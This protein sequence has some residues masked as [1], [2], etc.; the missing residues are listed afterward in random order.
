MVPPSNSNA[1][2]VKT[3]PKMTVIAVV[4]DLRGRARRLLD[5]LAAQTVTDLLEVLVADVGRKGLPELEPPPGLRVEIIR[6][7]PTSTWGQARA[8]ALRQAR[9]PLVALIEDHCYPT[10]AWAEALLD[11]HRGPW[12]A[13]GYAFTNPDPS[14]YVSRAALVVDYGRWMH[15]ARGGRAKLLSFNNV[16]YKRDALESLEKPL[17]ALLATDFHVQQELRR[18]GMPMYVEARAVAAHE[19][20]SNL[21]HLLAANHD[22]SRALASDRSRIENWGR[23]RRLFHGVA[24]MAVAPLI[25]ILRLV[26]SLPGRR[27]VWCAVL[28]ASPV[29]LLSAVWTAVGES[30]GYLVGGGAKIEERIKHWEVYAKR[31]LGG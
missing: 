8:A 9:A 3:V 25:S 29:L 18:R 11:A 27:G 17:E 2:A 5:A 20:Y 24:T 15:P 28:A 22:Y 6:L 4:G 12:V 7:D 26:R 30:F 10:P 16:S 31:S 13:I 19:N 21:R 1:A 23:P 14:S